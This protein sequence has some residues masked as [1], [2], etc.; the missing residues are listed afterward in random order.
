MPLCLHR[1]SAHPAA[2]GAFKKA[3]I[4]PQF[5]GQA[6]ASAVQYPVNDH[7]AEVAEHE[8]CNPFRRRRAVQQPCAASL[9]Q[10]LARLAL[11]VKR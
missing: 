7:A 6:V 4:L 10:A 1:A 5:I 9:V 8:V 11:R 2:K 3:V